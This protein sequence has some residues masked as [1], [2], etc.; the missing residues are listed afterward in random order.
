MHEPQTPA[1]YASHLAKPSPVQPSD[2]KQ[3]MSVLSPEAHSPG[4]KKPSNTVTKLLGINVEP[5]CAGLELIVRDDIAVER[6]PTQCT[7]HTV[8]TPYIEGSTDFPS[9][10]FQSSCKSTVAK[11]RRVYP[12]LICGWVIVLPRNLLGNTPMAFRP[13]HVPT[14]E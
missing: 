12:D 13:P 9:N 10:R 11:Y 7:L 8:T 3:G 2:R 4:G 1:G 14:I 5:S 6:N